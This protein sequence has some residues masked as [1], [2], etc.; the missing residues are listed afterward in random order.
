MAGRFAAKIKAKQLILHHFS[1]RYRGDSQLESMK[2]MWRIEDYARTE[3]NLT[4]TNDVLAA[5]DLMTVPILT[6]GLMTAF[7]IKISQNNTQIPAAA[8][9][10]T[11]VADSV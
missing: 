7:N 3:S 9:A 4:G 6:P 2:I 10:G 5:W 11:V 8:V 1:P